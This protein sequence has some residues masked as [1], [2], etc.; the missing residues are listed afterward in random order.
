M[1]VRLAERMVATTGYHAFMALDG[2]RV[3]ALTRELL[4][5]PDAAVFVAERAGEVVGMLAM[6]VYPHPFSGARIAG[7]LVWFTDPDQRGDGVKLLR[8]AEA[9]ARTTDAVAVQMIAPT[10][11]VGEFYRAMGYTPIETAYQRG[12]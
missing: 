8:A 1:I 3:S 4:D 5:N 7:E 12:I 2:E 10:D 11:R 9:W 6:L